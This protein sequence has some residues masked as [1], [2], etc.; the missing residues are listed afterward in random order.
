MQL[1]LRFRVRKIKWGSSRCAQDRSSRS[2]CDRDE[3]PIAVLFITE[4]AT[5]VP[6]ITDGG[7][8]DAPAI[9][10]NQILIIKKQEKKLNMFK[11][12]KCN[13]NKN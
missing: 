5:R 12:V 1:T 7:E 8:W 11:V 9:P 4:V 3:S 13:N 10:V 2:R 6:P